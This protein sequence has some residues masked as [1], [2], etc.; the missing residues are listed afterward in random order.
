ME[1]IYQRNLKATRFRFF[2]DA[3]LLKTLSAQDSLRDLESIRKSLGIKQRKGRVYYGLANGYKLAVATPLFSLLDSIINFPSLVGMDIDYRLA[4]WWGWGREV[5]AEGISTRAAFTF[6]ESDLAHLV[7]PLHDLLMQFP[8]SDTWQLFQEVMSNAHTWGETLYESALGG[9]VSW[10]K[11]EIEDLDTV[12]ALRRGAIER[13]DDYLEDGTMSSVLAFVWRDRTPRNN[14][15]TEVEDDYWWIT[16]SHLDPPPS[17]LAQ[18]KRRRGRNKGNWGNGLW[19]AVSVAL[20]RLGFEAEE[21]TDASALFEICTASPGQ[22][23]EHLRSTMEDNWPSLQYG[24][25]EPPS[26]LL[27]RLITVEEPMPVI[28]PETKLKVLVGNEEGRILGSYPI[29]AL[30]FPKLLE[31]AVSNIEGDHRVEVVRVKHPAPNFR[32][33]TWY[34]LA[35]RI[36]RF[37]LFSNASKWWVFY[38]AHGY[39]PSADSEVYAAERLINESLVKQADQINLIELEH[40]SERFL[41]DLFEPSAWKEVFSSVRGMVNANSDLRGVVPELL[42][43]EM[44]ARQHYRNIR[45]S[46]KPVLLGGLE[47]DSLGIRPSAGGGECL[48][49]EIKGQSSTDEVLA[50]DLE[51][52]ARK[53][54]TLKNHLPELAREVG[55]EGEISR[56]SGTFVSM[57]YPDLEYD[58]PDITLLDFDGFMSELRSVGI[59]SRL[60]NLLHPSRVYRMISELTTNAWFKANDPNEAAGTDEQLE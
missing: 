12:E 13:V 17:L 45:T 58:D 54:R 51:D 15:A 56:V 47:V 23:K 3:L 50:Q 31:V 42:A 27:D 39:G 20:N 7:A 30:D 43:T 41:L 55:Y 1:E 25:N 8:K 57:G 2:S 10:H 29:D 14:S 28:D 46:F 32:A 26:I 36:P 11:E 19:A 52:F 59:P 6:P 21:G 53:V 16:E 49:M 44:L 9:S 35:I 33:L 37:G 34:S 60:L 22:M 4:E 40:I 38:K 18:R 48:V 24:L 5:E